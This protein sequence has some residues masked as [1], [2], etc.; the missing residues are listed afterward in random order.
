VCGA[1]GARAGTVALIDQRS[2]LL[3]R[4]A[5]LLPRPF[6]RPRSWV[7]AAWVIRITGFIGAEDWALGS[8]ALPAVQD[9]LRS[10]DVKALYRTH[11]LW[12]PFYC[13]ECD[14]SKTSQQWRSIEHYDDDIF[15][16]PEGWCPAGH[17]RMIED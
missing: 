8:D 3:H 11:P 4:V 9:A 5:G 10:G 17:R 7:T 16:Y 1:C 2:S 13:P 15:E 12:A 6:R 14:H